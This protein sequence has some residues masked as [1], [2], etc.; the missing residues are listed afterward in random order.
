MVST[1]S[2]APSCLTIDLDAIQNNYRFICNKVSH[3][4]S[5]A[6]VKADGYGLGEVAVSKALFNAGC[7]SF[8]TAHID[9]AIAVKQAIPHASVSVMNGLLSGEESVYSEYDLVPTLNDL[10]QIEL[11]KKH[12]SNNGAPQANLQFDTG[13]ARLGLMPT[14]LEELCLDLSKLDGIN[15]QYIMSHMACADDPP[16]PLNKKQQK[17]FS[18]AIK[19]LPKVPAMLAASSAVFL[20]PEWHFDMVRPGVALYGGAP[21]EQIQNPLSQVVRLEGKVMQVREVNEPQ[22]VGYSALFQPKSRRLIATVAAGYADGFIRSLSS[23]AT[24]YY[25]D[26]AIP[27]VGRVSM[28]VITIDV[29]D[30]ENT[31]NAI[32]PGDTVD[33]IGPN[34]D[35]NALAKE[36][37]TIS[38][39]ILTSLGKRYKRQYV[40]GA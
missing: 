19:R 26:H 23:R 3:G 12:C 13:M 31:E 32:K 33:L 24:V 15:L 25:K 39:E 20:G 10:N 7:R 5:A 28:D 4:K 1:P 16:H 38:Y 37:G 6:V 22:S 11:W 2:H 34:H 8:F 14:E 27:V 29:S 40:G 9:E 36:A 35:I 21:N 30:L 18:S 17:D